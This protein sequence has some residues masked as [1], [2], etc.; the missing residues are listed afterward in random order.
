MVWWADGRRRL[1]CDEN[2]ESCKVALLAPGLRRKV[3]MIAR[4]PFLHANVLLLV[5]E[6]EEMVLLYS[7]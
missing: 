5:E 4:N 2:L 3:K 1:L 6:R 7:I